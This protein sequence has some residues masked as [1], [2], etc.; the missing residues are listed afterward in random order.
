MIIFNRDFRVFT[1]FNGGI[2]VFFD[3]VFFTVDFLFTLAKNFLVREV[4]VHLLNERITKGMTNLFTC[5][6]R[7]ITRAHDDSNHT[8]ITTLDG[9]NIVEST[10]WTRACLQ[11]INPINS[12]FSTWNR[13]VVGFK[14]FLVR[15]SLF[16]CDNRFASVL[17]NVRVFLDEIIGHNGQIT[18]SRLIALRGVVT[19]KGYCSCT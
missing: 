7:P 13:V 1:F 9:I 19:F 3:I 2:D 15:C 17:E 12:V 5:L 18:R 14:G 10:F 6:V 8:L 4:F 11:P 16:N